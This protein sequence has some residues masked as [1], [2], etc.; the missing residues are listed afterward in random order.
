MTRYLDFAAGAF[1][2]LLMCGGVAMLANGAGD[3]GAEI[4]L[5]TLLLGYSAWRMIE[6]A[7]DD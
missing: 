7:I 4:V 1:L 2:A 5:L 6:E 3:K